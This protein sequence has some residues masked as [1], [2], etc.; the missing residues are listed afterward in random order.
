MKTSKLL[1]TTLRVFHL[2]NPEA[3]WD[4]LR[5]RLKVIAEDVLATPTE[6]ERLDDEA[7]RYGDWQ[8][9]LHAITR[10]EAL[11]AAQTK[12]AM[13]G[14]RILGAA[15]ERLHGRPQALVEIIDELNQPEHPDRRPAV[16]ASLSVSDPKPLPPV[17]FASLAQSYRKEHEANVKPSSFK[18][19]TYC[20]GTLS[21]ALGDLD[22]RIHTRADLIALRDT[23]SETRKPLSVN[24]LLTKLATVLKWAVD[25]DLIPKAYTQNLKFK[26]NTESARKAF[27]PEQI[28]TVMAYANALPDDS[29]AR[30]ALSLGV[31]TGARLN[32]YAQLTKKD[33]RQDGGVWVIDINDDNGKQIKTA[34]SRRL[35]P[36]TEGAYGFDLQAFLRFVEESQ[37]ETVLGVSYRLA[38]RE[39]NLAL[40]RL[41]SGD[42]PDLTLHSLRHSMAS[43]LQAQGVPVAYAQAILGQSSGTLAYDTYGSALPVEKL[44]EVLK[45]ALPQG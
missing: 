26:K 19:I 7:L 45:K 22:M 10:T 40:R 35:I 36:L 20:H 31:I 27:T 32:E 12:A 44:A 6:W 4:E 16:S 14:G 43:Q 33:I 38:G 15:Q 9:D 2:D 11:T 24:N 34:Q 17:T 8:S 5:E 23:L 25:N 42:D 1:Q 13:L 3:S 41:V 30:W 39:L 37:G 21:D 28:E 29:W 18:E